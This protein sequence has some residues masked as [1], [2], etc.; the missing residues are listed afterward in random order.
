[1]RRLAFEDIRQS[2]TKSAQSIKRGK[3]EEIISSLMATSLH[4]RTQVRFNPNYI[5]WGERR[6]VSE[7]C[8]WVHYLG[9]CKMSQ[10]LQLK[11][12]VVLLAL[13]VLLTM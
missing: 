2:E 9:N 6:V 8:S 10:P 13:V 3:I 1:M 12:R 11:V 4:W 7:I 5:V